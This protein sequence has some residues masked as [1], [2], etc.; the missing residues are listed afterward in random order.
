MKLIVLEAIAISRQVIMVA[1]SGLVVCIGGKI[2]K[3][4]VG[5]CM[6]IERGLYENTLEW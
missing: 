4:S 5:V 1:G 2:D 6:V 3:I